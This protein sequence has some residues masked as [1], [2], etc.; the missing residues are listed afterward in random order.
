M[1]WR[2]PNNKL[3]MSGP[4]QRAVQAYK[5]VRCHRWRCVCRGL[6]SNR[7]KRSPSHED[8]QNIRTGLSGLFHEEFANA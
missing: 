3:T 7:G 8:I 4:P 1:A 5:R 6:G 2:Q